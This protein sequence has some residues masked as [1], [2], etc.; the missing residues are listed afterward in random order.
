M[1]IA[2]SACKSHRT[3]REGQPDVQ[4]VTG[5]GRP[6]ARRESEFTQPRNRTPSR[7]KSTPALSQQESSQGYI[8]QG[9]ILSDPEANQGNRLLTA[10]LNQAHEPSSAEAIARRASVHWR[11]LRLH[12]MDP[13]HRREAR[14]ATAELKGSKPGLPGAN[15]IPP[16]RRA[17]TRCWRSRFLFRTRATP[18]SQPEAL[19]SPP[20]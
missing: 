7:R 14:V 9:Y 1:A 20:I 5:A 17:V 4:M 3:W 6:A 16:V 2:K 11:R 10:R 18:A 13:D 12:G 15:R 19:Q 8:I